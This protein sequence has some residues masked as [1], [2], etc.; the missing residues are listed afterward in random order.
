MARNKGTP[1]LIQHAAPYPRI[2]ILDLTRGLAV[3]CMAIFHLTFDLMLFGHLPAGYVFE[4]GWPYFARGIASSFLFMAGLSA[5]MSHGS[6]IRWSAVWRRFAMIAGAAV[7]VSV[8]T[9]V[10]MPGEFVRWGI[11]HMIAAGSLIG[12][13]FLRVP[14]ALTVAVAIVA[15]VLPHVGRAEVFDHPALIWVGLSTTVRPMMDYEPVLPWLCPV[16]LGVAFGR[17]GS[18]RGLWQHLARW[19][20]PPPFRWLLWPGRHSLGIY[21]VHQPILFGLVWAY[22]GAMA[23]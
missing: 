20:V 9:Y 2:D 23:G 16:L 6:A 22:T 4:G 15:F 5:W 10:A 11:L 14:V 18:R 19:S 7:L 8:G 21:L 1:T 12:L 17:W 3:V 13:A